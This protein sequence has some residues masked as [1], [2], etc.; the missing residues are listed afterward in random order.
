MIWKCFGKPRSL[1]PQR[2]ITQCAI[3]HLTSSQVDA[4]RSINLTP[5]AVS[6]AAYSDEASCERMY[7]GKICVLEWH[8]TPYRVRGVANGQDMYVAFDKA[9]ETAANVKGIQQWITNEF[10]HSG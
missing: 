9:Q 6:L 7:C 1:L 8:A 4:L 5:I 10:M 3:S 2:P